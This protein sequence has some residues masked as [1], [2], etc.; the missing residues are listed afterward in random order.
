VPPPPIAGADQD[1]LIFRG[2]FFVAPGFHT[3]GA[4]RVEGGGWVGLSVVLR[5]NNKFVWN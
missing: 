4:T 3:E 1:P 2:R 5:E